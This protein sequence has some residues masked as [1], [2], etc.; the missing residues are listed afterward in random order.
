MGSGGAI[1]GD[2]GSELQQEGEQEKGE[3]EEKDKEGILKARRAGTEA[4]RLG[5]VRTRGREGMWERGS[6]KS[7][8][9]RGAERRQ[10]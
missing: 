6:R 4:S 5:Q 7:F 2:V 10:R 1:V 8:R 3:E 9:T